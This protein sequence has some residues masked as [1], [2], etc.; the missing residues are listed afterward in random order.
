MT[1]ARK[2]AAAAALSI[3]AA[4]GALAPPS[5][6]LAE[7][8]R[9]APAADRLSPAVTN[10]TRVNANIATAGRL[11]EGAIGELKSAGFAA[12]LDLRGADEG[13][14]AERRAV[15]A[16]GLRYVNIPVTSV[17]P[18]DGQIEEFQRVVED[19][20]N[21]PI[22]VHC[23]SGNRVGVMWT[24][25]RAQ[26]GAPVATALEEGRRIGM[27]GERE[28]AVLKRLGNP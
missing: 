10:Y 23:A 5:I 8:A 17:I 12:I 20:A 13:V 3:A 24:L 16:A 28:T 11:Q 26:R 6:S 22:L 27:R 15:E 21:F 18:S 7:A 4:I 1:P 9:E 2:I 14:E 25:Y 19:P